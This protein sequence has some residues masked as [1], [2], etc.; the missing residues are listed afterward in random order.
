MHAIYLIALGILYL[1][2]IEDIIKR[3]VDNIILLCYV[4]TLLT[5]LVCGLLSITRK[6]LVI[7]LGVLFLYAMDIIGE[8]DAKI[9]I[10]GSL[11]FEYRVTIIGIVLSLTA[12]L[13]VNRRHRKKVPLVALFIMIA[14]I[15][16]IAF[17]ELPEK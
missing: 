7:A 6:L 2:A 15:L 16:T 10:L 11:L 5:A 9:F 14:S 8:G 4:L 13:F 12:V 3:E 1:A 17:G